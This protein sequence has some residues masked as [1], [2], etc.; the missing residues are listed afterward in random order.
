MRSKFL[1]TVIF[2]L[3][4]IFSFGQTEKINQLDND[5]RKHGKWI[6][7]LDEKWKPVKDSKALY[8]RYTYYN[9][10]TDV[11]E[12]VAWGKKGWKLD[13]SVSRDTVKKSAPT[14]LNGEYTWYDSKGRL[15]SIIVYV[16]GEIIS[17]K[18]YYSSGELHEHLDYEKKYKNEKLTYYYYGYNKD[19]TLKYEG[20]F[21]KGDKG[22]AI[23]PLSVEV[24]SFG[25]TEEINQF[26]G[27]DDRKHGKWIIYLDETWKPVKD[28]SKALYFR[29]TYYYY[30]KNVFE[31]GTFGKKWKLESSESDTVKKS[32]PMMLNGEYS[33]YDSKGRLCYVHVFVDGELVSFK[34]Y[35]SSG[36]LHQHFDYEKKYNNEQL[37]YFYYE[38]NKDGTL[39]YEGVM[40]KGDKG[41]LIYN[42][43]D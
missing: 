6:I 31:M 3:V 1:F 21:R 42:S 41:W 13:S 24:F 30:G 19:G 12:R 22:W 7:Y 10:G 34:E 33:R 25:Q 9:R 37:T 38:Y 35:Y 32:T 11:F 5:G 36:E 2:L 28:S 18:H 17:C 20:V 23:Y 14:M 26:A 8:F 16:D 40:R 43:Q 15:S 27:G 4:H 39:K 29:Y